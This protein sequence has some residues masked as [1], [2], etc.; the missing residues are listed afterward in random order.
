MRQ[1]TSGQANYEL[2]D[3]DWASAIF[4]FDIPEMRDAR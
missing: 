3:V 2:T 4:H 1:F